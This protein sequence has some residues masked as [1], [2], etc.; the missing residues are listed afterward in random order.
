M[1]ADIA[2]AQSDIKGVGPLGIVGFCMGPA[3]FLAACRIPGFSAAVSFYGGMIGQFADE[4]PGVRCKCISARRTT[5]F[6]WT[7]WRPSEETA[8]GRDL[9][10]PDA[11]RPVVMSARATARRR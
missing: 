1:I 10:L 4:K 9:H 2:A 3:S 5:A 11:A 6:R 8:T 7:S